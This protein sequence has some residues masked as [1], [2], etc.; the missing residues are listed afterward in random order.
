M[1]KIKVGMVQQRC[2]TDIEAN[3]A[4]L[5]RHIR[6]CARQGAQVP[7]EGAQLVAVQDIVA[8]QQDAAGGILPG[9]LPHPVAHRLEAVGGQLR[10]GRVADGRFQGFGPDDEKLSDLL[11]QGHGVLV[12]GHA[13]SGP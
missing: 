2:T 1:D 8:V 9:P 10:V 13:I 3:I 6:A 11:P 12:S 5:E 7:D 4:S